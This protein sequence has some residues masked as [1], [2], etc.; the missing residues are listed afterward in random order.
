MPLIF[1]KS[2]LKSFNLEHT[3]RSHKTTCNSNSYLFR[4]AKTSRVLASLGCRLA[5]GVMALL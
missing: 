2:R 4:R 1:D 3:S 5:S